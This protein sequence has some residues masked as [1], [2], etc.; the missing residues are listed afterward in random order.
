MSI[1]IPKLLGGLGGG[2]QGLLSQDKTQRAV[3]EADS[4][5]EGN[6]MAGAQLLTDVALTTSAQELA[7]GLGKAWTGA[8]ITKASTTGLS[9]SLGSSADDAINIVITGSGSATVDILVF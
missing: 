6:L 2:L 4:K 8:F 1:Q 5:I 3:S 7:H 9:I